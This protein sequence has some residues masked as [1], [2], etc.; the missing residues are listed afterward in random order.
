MKTTQLYIFPSNK[1]EIGK[2][3]EPIEKDLLYRLTQIEEEYT[4]NCQQ[5]IEKYEDRARSLIGETLDLTNK[6]DR[7]K[8]FTK[9]TK[10][11]TSVIKQRRA[12]T[13][14]LDKDVKNELKL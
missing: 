11:K 7:R 4:K 9:K 14:Q 8:L 12:R 13:K 10:L 2:Q 5:P 1:K 3:H 6:H